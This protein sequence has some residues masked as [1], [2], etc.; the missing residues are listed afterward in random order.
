MALSYGQLGFLFCRISGVTT[1]PGSVLSLPGSAALNSRVFLVK[2]Y[3]L[4]GCF[5]DF[6]CSSRKLGK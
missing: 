1:L 5:K 6:L 3:R 2:N 4:G